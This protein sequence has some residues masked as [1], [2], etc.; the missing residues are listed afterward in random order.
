MLSSILLLCLALST[1]ATAQ[2]IDPFVGTWKIVP[3]KSTYENGQPPRNFTRTYE[4]RGGGVLLMT[5]ETVNNQGVA[6]R[7]Y[8]AFKRD[9]KPYP[10][11]A[12]GA[13]A[14]RMSATTAVDS[15]T[16]EVVFFTDGV[17]VETGTIRTT[18]TVS[19]DGK[20]LTQKMYILGQ[21]GRQVT[22]TAVYEKQPPASPALPRAGKSN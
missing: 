14:V 8:V 22:N 21:D 16:D 13:T 20:S 19:K 1:L 3:E 6:R 15:H 2:T 5:I 11:G 17:R 4:D 7:S 10:E 9:G 12:V 18:M